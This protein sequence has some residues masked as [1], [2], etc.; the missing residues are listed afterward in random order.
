MKTGYMIDTDFAADADTIFLGHYESP[1]AALMA[2]EKMNEECWEECFAH[3]PNEGE[4]TCLSRIWPVTD[5]EL[6][7]LENYEAAV[8]AGLVLDLSQIFGEDEG[9]GE[10][11]ELFVGAAVRAV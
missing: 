7:D 6:S 4:I 2:A 10:D 9:E 3:L 1:A 5:P 8:D 11:D